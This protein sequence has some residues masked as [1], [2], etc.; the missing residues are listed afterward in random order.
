M[1]IRRIVALA[2]R[3]GRYGGPFDTSSRQVALLR[4]AGFE[5]SVIAGALTDDAPP[6]RPEL[7]IFPV[8]HLFGLRSFVYVGSLHLVRALRPYIQSADL[9]HVSFARE[10]VPIAA[11][12]LALTR[13]K[14]LVLQPHGMLTT[15]RRRWAHRVLDALVVRPLAV[16]AS[17]I[18]ALT[19]RERRE[20]TAWEPR[21][22]KA[23]DV[24]GNPPPHYAV[25]KSARQGS[26]GD[27]V[28]VLFAARLH[29]RKHV[30]DFAGAASE[31]GS[32]GWPEHYL[33]LGPDE[34]DLQALR[35]IEERV[36]NLTYAGATDHAGVL[37]QL[38]SSR[39]FVLCSENEPWGNVLVAALT[40]GKPVVVTASSALAEVIEESDAGRVV[41]DSDVVGLAVA[42][43]ELLDERRYAAFSCRARQLAEDKFSEAGVK[44]ALL[45]AYANA[46]R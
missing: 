12:W 25:G 42:I 6:E 3:T 37:E 33:V 18:I 41:P 20:L 15:S 44:A 27:S 29:P 30:L 23:I 43:H 11:T 45:R 35:A 10:P 4:T 7:A 46:L 9:V 17:R 38:R 39:V 24:V 36:P 32:R 31:A 2:S 5:A 21:L 14:P 19:E 28:D 13:G 34:G 8:R 16:R 40:Y 1:R 22:A 26:A